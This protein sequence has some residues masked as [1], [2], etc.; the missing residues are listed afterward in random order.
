[1]PVALYLNGMSGM[2]P[3]SWM[4]WRIARELYALSAERRSMLKFGSVRAS[5]G[6]RK[7]LSCFAVS[8]PSML[9]TTFVLVPIIMCPLIQRATDFSR[10]AHCTLHKIETRVM[11][12]VA[13]LRRR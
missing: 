8:V 7:W 2:A 5:S 10:S 6:S 13:E 4:R 9:V 3:A 11:E 1:M 12:L